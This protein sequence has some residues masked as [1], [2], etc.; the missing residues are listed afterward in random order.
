MSKMHIRVFS[1]DPNSHK[2][3]LVYTREKITSAIISQFTA[4]PLGQTH[5]IISLGIV[6]NESAEDFDR[7]MDMLA[8]QSFE[9]L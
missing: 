4:P 1:F 9:Y 2:L 6:E 5:R 7:D 8:Y 3:T